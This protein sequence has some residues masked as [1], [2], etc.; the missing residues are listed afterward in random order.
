[1]SLRC[2][3]CPLLFN[4]VAVTTLAA[5][6]L[7]ERLAVN[8]L[9]NGGVCFMSSDLNSVESTEIFIAAVVFAL[10][11]GALDGGIGRLVF[12]VHNLII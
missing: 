2:L 9:A 4:L 5:A 7:D 1:M 10:L 3:D 8:A 12:H 11:Y 6:L